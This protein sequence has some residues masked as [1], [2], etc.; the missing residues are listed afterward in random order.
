MAPGSK[1]TLS[2]PVIPTTGSDQGYAL[3]NATSAAAP[4]VSGVAALLLSANPS[5]T[6]DQVYEALTATADST[7]C[8]TSPTITDT[9]EC[10]FGRIDARRAL[11]YALEEWGGTIADDVTIRAGETWDLG[12]V[13]LAFAPGTELI[14]EGTLRSDGTTFTASDPAQ[15]WG[16][17][18]FEAGSG[19]Q[20]VGSLVERVWGF[21]HY[22]VR[23]TDASPTFDVL[24]INN[25]VTPSAVAGLLVTG[26]SAN[27]V[28][29]EVQIENMTYDGI[30]LS[31]RARM[32]MTDG[33][34]TGND[35]GLL[36][37]YNTR[38][39]LYPALDGPRIRGNQF[40][41]N[42]GEGLRA[43]SSADL[44]FGYYHY[45][46]SGIHND[47]FNTFTE[48]DGRGILITNTAKVHGGGSSVGNGR[49]RIFDNDVNDAVVSG[50]GS[51]LHG[52]CNWWDSGEL[53]PSGAVATSGGY[54]T[55][56]N[57]LREDPELNPSAPC[58][59]S[60]LVAGEPGERRA[61]RLDAAL[62]LS[63][64]PAEAF[65]ALA[66]I[67]THSPSTPE[68]ASAMM[69]IARLAERDGAPRPA[70]AFVEKAATTPGP[71]EGVARRALLSLRHQSGDARGALEMADRLVA[72]AAFGE[73]DLFEYVAQV[74]L[75][76]DLGQDADALAAYHAIEAV[77]PGSVEARLA[78]E[79]LG[80]PF[81]QSLR[82]GSQASAQ[83]VTEA[84]TFRIESV[85]PNP[86]SDSALMTYTLGEASEVRVT[87]LDVLGREAAVLTD[88]AQEAGTHTVPVDGTRFV[89]GVYVIRVETRGAGA[90][91][92]ATRRFTVVR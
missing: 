13:T 40:V 55:V 42:Q 26:P 64:R 49:N 16:G 22:A 69:E 71:M 60:S 63:E 87:V 25:P 89:S 12:A 32:R 30:V 15:G 54:L 52:V 88:G 86:M 72:E 28:L 21:G 6:R 2:E 19:G 14:V 38:A 75:Y 29:D 82:A 45:P 62:A 3:F 43:T 56:S 33:I 84:P 39:F 44:T 24:R 47:G 8:P 7:G 5:L 23:V 1:G 83:V 58:G 31:N 73:T 18:R 35:R 37:G 91:D 27:P 50:S 81:E 85:R 76:S 11:V 65:R 41:D 9:R 36:A 80:L 4:H 79:Y 90:R 10:G 68:A 77:A 57:W 67:A 51:T 48:N 34:V 70:L 20:L 74:H 59:G 92:E 66:E 17:I 61:G 46:I 53:A 78:R